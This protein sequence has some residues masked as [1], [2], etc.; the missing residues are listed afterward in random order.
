MLFDEQS[1]RR[2]FMKTASAATLG[3]LAAGAPR[4]VSG[5]QV[6]HPKATADTCILLWMAGGMCHTETFDCY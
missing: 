2:D 5:E 6:K 4:T 1:T 3:A